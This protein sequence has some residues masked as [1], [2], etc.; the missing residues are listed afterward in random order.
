MH[1]LSPNETT[2]LFTIFRSNEGDGE[3]SSQIPIFASANM[4]IRCHLQQSFSSMEHTVSPNEFVMMYTTHSVV[5]G[6]H[7]LNFLLINC[8]LKETLTRVLNIGTL[9]W[10]KLVENGIVHA[11]C[12][13]SSINAFRR[14]T[15]AKFRFPLALLSLFPFDWIVLS[16]TTSSLSQAKSPSSPHAT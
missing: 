2:T 1:S 14:S 4:Q 12:W 8:E 10:N 7:Y 15:T 13:R 3:M 16:P 9:D 6:F 5:D 11:N